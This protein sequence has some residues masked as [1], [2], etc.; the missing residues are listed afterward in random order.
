MDTV[1]NSPHDS[2]DDATQTKLPSALSTEEIQDHVRTK[3]CP[4]L[5]SQEPHPLRR[6]KELAMRRKIKVRSECHVD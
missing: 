2:P 4:I 6:F 5:F 3:V 1:S